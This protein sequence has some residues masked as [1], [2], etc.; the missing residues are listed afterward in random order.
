MCVCIKLLFACWHIF[1]GCHSCPLGCSALGCPPRSTY[2]CAAGAGAEHRLGLGGFLLLPF[3]ERGQFLALC[4]AAGA[5]EMN[6]L[7][8]CLDLEL[9]QETSLSLVLPGAAAAPLDISAC[10]LGSL[11]LR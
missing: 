10:P 1:L 4:G 6:E 3:G 9:S 7:G 2:A 5:S 11:I 8:V